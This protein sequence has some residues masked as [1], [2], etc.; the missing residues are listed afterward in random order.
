MCE[1]CNYMT[2]WL[3]IFY[4][5]LQGA[6]EFLPISSS[7]HLVLFNKIFGTNCD[8][9]LF[10]ILLHLATLFAV[11]VVLWKDIKFLVKKTFGNGAMKLYIATIFSIIIVLLFKSTFEN[12]FSGAFLPIC[13]LITASLLL[14][15]EILGRRASNKKISKKTAVLIGIAQGIAVFPAI[16]RSG[17]TICTAI[18]CG[19]N[20]ENASRFSFLLSIPIILASVVYE[21]F[22]AIKMGAPII[23][24]PIIPTI[25]AFLSAFV[26]GVLCLKFMLKVFQKIK[27]W[28]FSIYLVFISAL[29]FFFI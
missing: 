16:S 26:V 27:L 18:L 17:A 15:T 22:D 2:I 10:S 20:R 9:I 13:F 8:F 12:A 6:T 7:G 25:F 4:G 5:V 29:S 21:I 14:I 1:Y 23:D 11:V 28:Y 3:A 19:V 24:T